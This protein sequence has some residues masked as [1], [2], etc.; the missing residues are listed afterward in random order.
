MVTMT[1][2]EFNQQRSAAVR[3]AD[4]E[5][6][7]ILRDGVPAYRLSHIAAPA[8]TLASE[9]EAGRATPPQPDPTPAKRRR[10]LE[11]PVDLVAE[12]I[13]E[14]QAQRGARP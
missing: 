10:V 11:V 4:T 12:S 7:L 3:M 8:R 9:V 13:T 14:R 6:V 2:T 5:D 1:L